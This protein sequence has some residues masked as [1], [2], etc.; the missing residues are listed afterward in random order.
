MLTEKTMERLRILAESA[1]YDVSCSSSG[2]VRKGKA[3]MVG[4]T[5][6]GVG[7]CH[8]FADDGRCISLL[9]V[10]LTNHCIYDCAY[11]VNR[12]SNDI[13]R[14]TLSVSELEEITMEFY[15]RNYIE[16]LFLSSGV[17]RNPDYTMERLVA[18]V[19]DLRTVHRFNGYIHLKSIP[20]ASQEMLSE[21]GRYADRMS[22]NIEIPR[23]ESLKLLAPEK[24]HRSVFQPMALI[25]QGVLENKEDRRKFRHAPRFVPAGQSTQ[26]IVGATQDTDRDILQMSSMLY[27]QP[28]LRRVYYSGYISVN[29]YD[30]RLPR[31]K[32]PPLVRE[33]RLYQ[34]DW[35]MR[36]YHFSVNEIVDD[37]HAH[38]DLDIDPKLSWAQRHP[39]YFPV[40]INRDDYERLLRV[41]GLGTRSA[42]LI[43]N[44]RRFGRLTSYDLKRMGVVM[45][46]ARYFIT[47]GELTDG[48][49][50]PL[51]GIN[52]L[53]PERLRPLL[54][55]KAQQRRAAQEQQ[56]QL[57]FTDE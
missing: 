13:R 45:K 37:E 32:Q 54:I 7:I 3:G 40:D 4:N 25:Q 47:C 18:I 39:E 38:L 55:S 24:D 23:E 19:R 8:S 49:S 27:G 12:R 46:K 14:A 50:Q 35:L 26:M 56:L 29:T 41:P 5:V 16:G 11:C 51:V 17:V 6:G 10:M 34:A 42:W 30:P 53:H 44:S 31:L 36:F 1:K 52:E 2:T 9:K 43:V 28:S 20:G 33:N 21:A 15:R 48:Y 22:V 57:N